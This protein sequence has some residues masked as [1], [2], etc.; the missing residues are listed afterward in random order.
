MAVA[1]QK[2]T[3][4]KFLDR[5]RGAFTPPP[6]MEQPVNHIPHAAPTTLNPKPNATPKLAHPYGDM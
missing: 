3:L 1:S 2:M 6:T 4:I 5:M